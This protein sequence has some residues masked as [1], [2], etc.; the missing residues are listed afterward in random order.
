LFLTQY[1]FKW[2][3]LY[4]SEQLSVITVCIVVRVSLRN[5]RRCFGAR[6]MNVREEY[7]ICWNQIS[8]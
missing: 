1:K 8:Q 5:Y 4:T 3:A 7:H 2:I 6:N